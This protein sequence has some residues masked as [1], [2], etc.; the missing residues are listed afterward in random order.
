MCDASEKALRHRVGIGA[1]L[2]GVALVG[3]KVLVDDGDVAGG[4]LEVEHGRQ[5][6]VVDHDGVGGVVRLVLGAGQDD[7]HGVPDV[8]D[9]AHRR[10]AGGPAPSCQR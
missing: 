1:E 6:L 9:L 10:A 5:G 4:R 8:A 3:A 7:R 2:P